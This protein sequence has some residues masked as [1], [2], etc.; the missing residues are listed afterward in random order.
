MDWRREYWMPEHS[1]RTAHPDRHRCPRWPE[2]GLL[3]KRAFS[4]PLRTTFRPARFR[5]GTPLEG[6]EVEVSLISCVT[7]SSLLESTA[8]RPRGGRAERISSAIKNFGYKQ[9]KTELRRYAMTKAEYKATQPVPSTSRTHIV[10]ESISLRRDIISQ[11]AGLIIQYPSRVAKPVV[12]HR[13]LLP[14]HPDVR[15]IGWHSGIRRTSSISRIRLQQAQE[16]P[17]VR[18]HDAQWRTLVH[19]DKLPAHAA[20][21]LPA[22]VLAEDVDIGQGRVHAGHRG[23]RR[24]RLLRHDLRRQGTLH[25]LGRRHFVPVLRGRIPGCAVLHPQQQHQLSRTLLISAVY[26]SS[27]SVALDGARAAGGAWVGCAGP[28]LGRA[29]P[30]A[31]R[32]LRGG[33]ESAAG[34][35]LSTVV[36]RK[37]GRP[38]ARAAGGRQTVRPLGVVH[39]KCPAE[40]TVGAFRRS[41]YQIKLLRLYLC[42]C[43]V[44]EFVKP[45][46]QKSEERDTDQGRVLYTGGWRCNLEILRWRLERNLFPEF[47]SGTSSV[48]S[49]AELS[50]LPEPLLA[51]IGTFL[52]VPDFCR[53]TQ[54]RRFSFAVFA[55]AARGF[56]A[57]AAIFVAWYD[58]CALDADTLQLLTVNDAPWTD[59]PSVHTAGGEPKAVY[60]EHWAYLKRMEAWNQYDSERRLQEF[61]LRQQAHWRWRT[62]GRL[63]A[64]P[65]HP[66]MPPPFLPLGEDPWTLRPPHHPGLFGDGDLEFLREPF[67][68]Y[69]DPAYPDFFY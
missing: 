17:G 45:R 22:R 62:G 32:E 7:K 56:R 29:S 68:F 58:C 40:S 51:R 10:Y 65:L 37:P 64:P 47:S 33:R 69:R 15:P 27:W 49:D 24:R 4:P 14:G 9:R 42:Y 1:A 6:A 12:G 52:S 44:S 43:R 20:D 36:G 61:M 8:K 60:R 2:H 26:H 54:T 38:R 18:H 39:Q 48:T 13:W 53:V 66:P 59:Y 11:I 23:V 31:P 50:R 41:R 55:S 19:H 63:P 5:T 21:H 25:A 67:T 35:A 16:A 28:R 3:H 30:P 57:V 34:A 46:G